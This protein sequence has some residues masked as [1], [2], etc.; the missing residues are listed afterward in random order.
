MSNFPIK[1]IC[2][3]CGEQDGQAC[4]DY[5]GRHVYGYKCN[6]CELVYHSDGIEN[7]YRF[8]EGAVFMAKTRKQDEQ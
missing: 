4:D 6:K 3:F 5:F 1:I 7:I 2:P 8:K